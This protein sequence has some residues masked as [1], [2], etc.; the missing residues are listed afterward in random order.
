MVTPPDPVLTADDEAFLQRVTS[1]PEQGPSSGHTDV[2]T[3]APQCENS[4]QPVLKESAQDIPL[5]AS[6]A[7]KFGMELGEEERKAREKS[8]TAET[9]PEP[10]KQESNMTSEKKKK[11]WS[12]MFW[13]KTGDTEKVSKSLAQDSVIAETSPAY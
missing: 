5:P 13:K 7:E 12:S 10:A 9:S 11:R 6:P 8:E 4:E 1:Q 2:S 3:A